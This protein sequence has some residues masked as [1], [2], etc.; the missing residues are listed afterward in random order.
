[1]KEKLVSRPILAL[2]DPTLTT[3]LYTDASKWGVGG[4]LFQRQGNGDLKPVAYFSRQTT[5]IEQHFSS[6]ELETLAVVTSL[7]KFRPYLLGMPFTIITDCN[8]LRATFMKRDMILRVAR[9]WNLIQEFDCD[10]KY[11]PGQGMCHVDALSR[12]AIPNNN[13]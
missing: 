10:V 6:Y 12:N 13:C 8:S 1:M 3:E 4:I 2:Y 9:W 11:K 5:P 7:V